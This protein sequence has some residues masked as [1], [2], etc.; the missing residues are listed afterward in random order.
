MNFLGRIFGRGGGNE[1]PAPQPGNRPEELANRLQKEGRTDQ[2]EAELL[3]LQEAGLTAEERESWHHLFGIAAFQRQDHSAALDRFQRGHAQ[4]PHS[5]QIAFSLGQE[6][7]H[8]GKPDEMFELFDRFP[9]PAIPPRFAM[10]AARYAYLWGR[11]DKGLRYLD[12]LLEAY[13]K[14]GIADDQFLFMRGFPFFGETWAYIALFHVLEGRAGKVAELTDVAASRLSDFDFQSLKWDASAL[15]TQN[16]AEVIGGLRKQSAEAKANKW[17][18]GY[19]E[20][21]AAVLTA[22]ETTDLSDAERWINSVTLGSND[23]RWLEDIRLL[24]RCEL[25]H[26]RG[27]GSAEREL[28]DEFLQR[29]PLLFEPSHALNFGLWKYQEILKPIY[30]ARKRDAA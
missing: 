25:S 28:V 2:L 11:A 18:S 9:F 29:Q 13:F 26:R 8:L 19:A 20:M 21:R 15:T 1:R 4:F 14:L 10:A 24:A 6:F 16:Y 7:E 27:V 17:P 22:H 3:K 30:Q 5:G 12:P 23:F